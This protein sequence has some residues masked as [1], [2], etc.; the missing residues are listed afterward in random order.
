MSSPQIF[1]HLFLTMPFKKLSGFAYRKRNKI[2]DKND[3]TCAKCLAG[4]LH[5]EIQASTLRESTEN[6]E[7]LLDTATISPNSSVENNIIFTQKDE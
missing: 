2:R 5:T 6:V 1:T 3:K 7:N 4:F